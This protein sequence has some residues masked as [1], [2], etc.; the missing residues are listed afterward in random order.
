MQIWGVGVG[1]FSYI[2]C[3]PDGFVLKLI[4]K[5]LISNE[6]CQAEH[7][8]VNIHPLPRN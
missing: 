4:N 8:Y 3:L 7:E 1:V 6:I 2:S 5:L